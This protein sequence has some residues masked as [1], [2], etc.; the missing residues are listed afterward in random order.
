M[1]CMQ[2]LCQL[3]IKLQI[4]PSFSVPVWTWSPIFN[5]DIV[6]DMLFS[7]VSLAMDG[8]HFFF[9]G[10]GGHLQHSYSSYTGLLRSRT[11][12]QPSLLQYWNHSRHVFLMKQST[13]SWKYCHYCN[14]IVIY[15]HKIMMDL[16][17]GNVNKTTEVNTHTSLS[18]VKTFPYLRITS[19]SCM[20]E[21]IATPIVLTLLSL[22]WNKR[23]III[24]LQ[25]SSISFFKSREFFIICQWKNYFYHNIICELRF[26]QI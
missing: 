18:T 20:S 8:K 1:P 7:R 10:G 25:K 15:L 13:T 4:K 23:V 2:T 16:W 26:I 6:T 14:T 22:K 11:L 21:I 9:F 17:M 12:S 5:W 3:V 24:V 19:M